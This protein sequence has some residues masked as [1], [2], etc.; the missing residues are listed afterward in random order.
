MNGCVLMRVKPGRASEALAKVK[1]NPGVR[2]AF[3]V[4]GGFDI[5][6]FVEAPTYEAVS[7]VTANLNGIDDLDSTETLL[8]ALS[9]RDIPL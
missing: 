5:V 8:E 3:Y 2:K 9:E 1:A 4:Y 6:A 7:R